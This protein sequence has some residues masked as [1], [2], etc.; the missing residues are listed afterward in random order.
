M[1]TTFQKST[2]SFKLNMLNIIPWLRFRRCPRHVEQKPREYGVERR[3]W[4]PTHNNP[5]VGLDD[6]DNNPSACDT[7]VNKITSQSTQRK[8]PPIVVVPCDDG[9]PKFVGARLHTRRAPVP[10]HWPL[11]MPL[12]V[13]EADHFWHLNACSREANMHPLSP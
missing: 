9:V 1:N 11:K 3:R 13:S 5:K 7:T 10:S 12:W 4:Q 8:T 6:V 2:K